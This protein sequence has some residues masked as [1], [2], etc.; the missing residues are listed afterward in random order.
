[1]APYVPLLMPELQKALV[2]P[3][4]EVRA[5][6]AR[7]M[8][9]LV[10]GMGA[11]G[12]L[13]ELLPWLL[14]TLRSEGSSVERSGAAQGLAE[15]LAV[16]GEAYLAELLPQLLANARHKN[17]YVREGTLL[18][19]RYLPLM[20]EEPFQDHLGEVLPT[21]LDGLSDEVEG[22][23]DAALEAG[24]V[25]VDA[26]AR[27]CLGLLLPAVEVGLG[28]ANWRIRQSSVELLGELLFKV[29]RWGV[30]GLYGSSSSW[31]RCAGGAR[32]RLLFGCLAHR[33][34]LYQDWLQSHSS[35][36]FV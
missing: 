23:R 13:A 35:V 31:D 32:M 2:D 34:L 14:A 30:Q 1:M 22:V 28:A 11:E 8:G 16:Q 36:C 6:A 27:S 25:L 18:L 5:T 26:Y 15:V 24:R 20:M 7:A 29:G 21:I 3:L 12:G 10:K 19:F 33:M 4:P 17:A 9:S